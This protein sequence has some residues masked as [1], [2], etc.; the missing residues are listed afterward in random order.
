MSTWINKKLISFSEKV[1]E[2]VIDSF[3]NKNTPIDNIQNMQGV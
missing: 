3:T 2:N 1:I